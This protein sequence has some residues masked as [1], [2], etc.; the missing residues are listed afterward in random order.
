MMYRCGKCGYTLSRTCPHCGQ[1][2]ALVRVP[3]FNPKDKYG[4]Y[5]KRGE[6]EV[7]KD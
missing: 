7:Q 2:T 5:R 4:K 1:R 3:K 6:L